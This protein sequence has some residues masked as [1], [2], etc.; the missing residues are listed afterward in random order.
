MFLKREIV[1]KIIVNN[2]I[3]LIANIFKNIF[4]DRGFD[5]TGFSSKSKFY[6]INDIKIDH[7]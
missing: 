6:L 5:I 3:D 2:G 4:C 1:T 7:F